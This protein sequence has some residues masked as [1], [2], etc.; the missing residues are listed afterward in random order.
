MSALTMQTRLIHTLLC[1]WLLTLGAGTAQAETT[2]L[3]PLRSGLDAAG[4]EAVGRLTIGQNA[5]CTGALIA[6][7][8]VLTAAHCLYGADR[9]TPVQAT[10]IQ[11]DAG[12]RGAFTNA[13]KTA[14]AY[15]IHP[16]FVYKSGSPTTQVAND[17]ALIQLAYPIENAQVRPFATGRRPRKWEEVSVV[18]YG[19]TRRDHPSLQAACPVMARQAGVLLLRC[20]VESGSSGAPVFTIDSDGN[21]QIVSVISSLTEIDGKPV[22]LG[23]DLQRPLKAMKEQLNNAPVMPN[24]RPNVRRMTPTTGRGAKFLRP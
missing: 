22:A 7:D 15:V 11:F 23:T 5:L 20:E 19:Y 13:S 6:P 18:S 4:W 10:D 21:P 2:G 3:K 14:R 12:L 16:D 24:P 1:L 8:L 17:L 9:S